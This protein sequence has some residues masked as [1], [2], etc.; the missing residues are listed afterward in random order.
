[1]LRKPDRRRSTTQTW[2]FHEGKLTCGLHGLVVQVSSFWQP[3]LCY[4]WWTIQLE[5]LIR[6]Q[7]SLVTSF[8]LKAG[9]KLLHPYV[10]MGEMLF[11]FFKTYSILKYVCDWNKW[12]HFSL[13]F[14]SSSPSYYPFSTPSHAPTASKLI[15]SFSLLLLSDACIHVHVC[16]CLY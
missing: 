15:A 2:S 13:P 11:S 8:L 1:M 14:L 12:H 16:T 5:K 9:K 4:T 6:E 10:P 3:Q 7:D